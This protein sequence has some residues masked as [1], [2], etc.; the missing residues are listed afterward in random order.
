M[1][2]EKENNKNN[3]DIIQNENENENENDNNEEQEENSINVYDDNAY[4]L[5]EEG[6]DKNSLNNSKNDNELYDYQNQDKDQQRINEIEGLDDFQNEEKE[7]IEQNNY[8]K[9]VEQNKNL[10]Q[11]IKDNNN[12]ENN[13]NNNNNI[14]IKKN[15]NNKFNYND[16]EEINIKNKE[17]I[18]IN[19]NNINN[20]INE[21]ENTKENEEIGEEGEEEGDEEENLPLVTLKYVSICQSCKNSFDSE[22]H[23]PYLFKC[24]HFFCK[25]CIEQQFTDEEGIKCPIDGLIAQTIKEFKLLNNLITDKTIPS[26]RNDNNNLY[27]N[28]KIH[29]GQKLTHIV[30]NTKEIVC[31]YCAFDLIRK[32]PNCEVKELKELF[33]DYLN[34]AEKIININQNN[35]EI[36]KNTLKDI[37]DNKQR[38]EKNVIFYFEHILKYIN[39]KKEEILSKIESIFT[40]NATKLSQKLENF[41]SQIEMGENLKQVINNFDKND[42]FLYNDIYE[43]YL[44]LKNLNETENDNKINLKEYKFVHDDEAKIMKYT[45]YFGDIKIIY[46][47]IPFKNDN[48][49]FF[50]LNDKNSNN[51]NYNNQNLYSFNSTEIIN[52]N[53][54]YKKFLMNKKHN[55]NILD[56]DINQINDYIRTQNINNL[57]EYNLKINKNNKKPYINYTDYQNANLNN[58]N[59]DSNNKNWNIYNLNKEKLYNNNNLYKLNPFKYKRTEYNNSKSIKSPS[60]FRCNTTN[61]NKDCFHRF[62]SPT[63]Y[64]YTLQR[65]NK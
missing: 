27:N 62:S 48:Q 18:N 40:E 55:L 23:L 16:N 59:S 53:N 45:N 47:Y 17:N 46:K 56:D 63:T 31:V 25:E 7:N 10:N 2:S 24:G 14:I 64:T 57:T 50:E 65:N 29:K 38:E 36:I 21:E 54:N 60:F 41:S 39:T 1:D 6:S 13:S 11:N 37:K 5:D 22:K 20:N 28:C 32:N 4:M 42:N 19:K 9:Y 34:N 52:N 30:V 61:N 12:S 58:N 8:L 44:K 35:V 33:E 3:E 43:G 51:N 49:E 15:I 26:Q